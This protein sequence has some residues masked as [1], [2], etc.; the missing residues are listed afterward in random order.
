MDKLNTVAHEVQLKE[1]ESPLV[2]ELGCVRYVCLRCM[3]GLDSFQNTLPV[4]LA[5]A[6]LYTNIAA[7]LS[8]RDQIRSFGIRTLQSFSETDRALPVARPQG[9]PATFA[10]ELAITPNG[11]GTLGTFGRFRFVLTTSEVTAVESQHVF[12]KSYWGR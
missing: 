4:L 5:S 2:A 7:G 1:S 3:E 8:T 10:V 9:L 6:G 11:A 12:V